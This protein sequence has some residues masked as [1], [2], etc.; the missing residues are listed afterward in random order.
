MTT[1]GGVAGSIPATPQAESIG[2]P[3]LP[4]RV[5]DFARRNEEQRLARHRPGSR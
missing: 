1:V 3:P 4:R 5:A 2:K